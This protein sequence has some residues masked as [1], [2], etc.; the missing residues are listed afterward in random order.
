MGIGS[1]WLCLK[2]LVIYLITEKVQLDSDRFETLTGGDVKLAWEWEGDGG[3][4]TAYSNEHSDQ[5][6][7]TAIAGKSK[8]KFDNEMLILYVFW[9][10]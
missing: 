7:N 2:G 4:W 1:F 8:V 5:L 9:N 3:V 6:T 10:C